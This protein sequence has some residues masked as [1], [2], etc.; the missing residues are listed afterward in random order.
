MKYWQ[1]IFFTTV[2]KSTE[3][4]YTFRGR[5]AIFKRM[6]LARLQGN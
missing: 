6:R 4:F 5:D 3:K 2:A 1:D